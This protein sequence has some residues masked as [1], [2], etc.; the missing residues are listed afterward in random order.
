MPCDQMCFWYG[1]GF[2]TVLVGIEQSIPKL[3]SLRD[4]LIYSDDSSGK[5]FGWD[6][7]NLTGCQSFG[8][9]FLLWQHPPKVGPP[10]N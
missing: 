7:R 5:A 3:A 1:F 10:M 9:H 8:P 2:G 4:F 6:L